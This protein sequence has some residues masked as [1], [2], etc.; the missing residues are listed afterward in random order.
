MGIPDQS[1]PSAPSEDMQSTERLT[2]EEVDVTMLGTDAILYT[3]E[4]EYATY[5]HTYLMP[6]LTGVRTLTRRVADMS[7]SSRARAADVPSTSR[8]NTSRGRARGMPPIR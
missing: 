1:I 4:G 5:H 2:P 3:E 6:P 7:S 8:A